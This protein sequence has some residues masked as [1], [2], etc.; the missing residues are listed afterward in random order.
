ME[1]V[2]SILQLVY[3]NQK[4][5]E[6]KGVTKEQKELISEIR[7]VYSQLKYTEKWFQ[8]EEDDDLIDACIYQRE[9][10]N[11]KYKYLIRKAKQENIYLQPFCDQ[12]KPRWCS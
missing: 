5:T 11:A 7:D 10:L 2:L 8:F 9:V 4:T 1:G 12:L 3:N 6:E